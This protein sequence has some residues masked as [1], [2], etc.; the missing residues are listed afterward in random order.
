[1]F[2]VISRRKPRNRKGGH[3]QLQGQRRSDRERDGRVEEFSDHASESRGILGV[4]GSRV[5][6][7]TKTTPRDVFQWFF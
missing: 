2:V 3:L 1:M 4:T 5:A 7:T 6:Y